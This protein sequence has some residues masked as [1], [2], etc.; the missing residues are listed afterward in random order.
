M[1]MQIH[2]GP[3][4]IKRAKWRGRKGFTKNSNIQ[5]KWG[6]S[7]MIYIELKTVLFKMSKS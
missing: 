6:V 7:C 1:T 4:V 2:E 3:K 5:Q